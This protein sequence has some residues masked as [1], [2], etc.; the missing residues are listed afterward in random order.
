MRSLLPRLLLVVIAAVVPALC[1]QA[2][3]EN[4]ARHVRQQLMSEEALRLVRFVSSEQQRIVDT[5]GAVLTVIGSAPEVQENVQDACLRL[6]ANVVA[7]SPSYDHIGVFDLQGRPT[8]AATVPGERSDFSDRYWFQRA[9]ETNGVVVGDYIV[10][11]H[12]GK[13]TVHLAKAFRN[14]DGVI[15]GVAAVSLNLEWL[16]EQLT[17][18]P[19]PPGASTVVADRNGTILAR[20]PDSAR[21]AGTPI[22]ARNR[23]LL[24]GNEIRV[25]PVSGLDGRPRLAAFS[26]VNAK[27]YGLMVAVGLDRDAAFATVTDGTRTGIVLIVG[28]L[29]LALTLTALLGTRLIRRPVL[30]LLNAAEHWRSGDLTARTGLRRDQGEFGRLA[31][32]FDGMAAA[33]E[34][35]E[36]ALRNALEST[37][38]TVIVLDRDWRFTYLNN[39]AKATLAHG[40]DFVGQVI[41]NVFP[42]AAAGVF[43]DAYRKAMDEGIPTHASAYY[44]PLNSYWEMHAYPSSDGLT[45][46]ARDVTEERR[47]AAALAESETL[48]RAAF[49]QAAV[50]MT[51]IAI[52]ETVL[53]VNDKLCEITGYTREELL[54]GRFRDIT[55]PDDRVRDR[56]VKDQALAGETHKL[57]LAKRYVR[58]DG[59]IVWVNMIGSALRGDHGRP[60]HFF[61]VIED[62]SERKG[63]EIALQASEDRLRIALEAARMGIWERHLNDTGPRWTPEAAKIYGI[64][65]AGQIE[66]ETWLEAVHPDDRAPT[67]R[68]WDRATAN[69]ENYYE[70]EYRVRQPDGTWRWLAS[71]ARM[72]YD[73]HGNVVR[74]VGAVQ[75]IGERKRVQEALQASET[76]LQ[77]ARAAAGFGVW[78]W[79][80]VADTRIW[81]DD[82][83]CLYGLAPQPGAPSIAVWRA[84]VHPDDL[85]QVL[86]ERATAFESGAALFDNEFRVTW[87]DGS[88]HWLFVKATIVHDAQGKVARIV[89]MTLDVTKSRQTEAELRRLSADLE[90]RV[91]EEMTARE[92]AQVRAAHAERMQA[93]GQLAGG[94]A[95]DFNNVLQAVSGAMTL[96]GRRPGDEAGIRRLAQLASEAT[97]RGASITRRLLAFGRRGDLRAET[98]DPSAL[99]QDL[100]EILAHTLGANIDVRVR[101]EPELRSFLADKGQLETSLINLATNARDAM[102]DGGTLTLAAAVEIVD[103]DA[104]NHPIGLDP[105]PYV[106]LVIHDTGVGMDAATLARASEPFFT[107]KKTGAGTGLGLAM[108]KGFA[109][110]SGGGLRVE[111]TPGRGTTI[112][113]WL[114]ETDPAAVQRAAQ[115]NE[116]AGTSPDGVAIPAARTRVLLV[117]DEAAVREVLGIYLEDAGF[118]VLAAASGSEALALLTAGETV[119]TLITDLSMPG[120]DGLALIQA[121]Q[122]RYPRMPALLLTGYA[123]DG[124]ALAVG[125]AVK[126]SFTLLRKPVQG[127]YLID[128]LRALLAGQS[129]TRRSTEP[130]GVSD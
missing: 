99:L 56:M 15:V 119:D 38:D 9:L 4:E 93:L 92:A 96:I 114:P 121:V 61:G 10:G 59:S 120:M 129:K 97:E 63:V 68:N 102:P 75:D 1:F 45:V 60:S 8:C 95:H 42:E 7:Q 54:K 115:T 105:G 25:I 101:L 98:I 103:A 74:A 16:A 58:K 62:I 27:P 125:G 33:L 128:R 100:R 30:Q 130:H 123:G 39:R 13:P 47:I 83:W 117:D 110:Q 108:A 94:I 88:V 116:A 44:P 80:Y 113:L 77:L 31:T 20:Y 55:H 32:A 34:A 106:R 14:R 122:A 64:G 89:G 53:R 49:E 65:S 29:L 67:M 26:P 82:Q 19:L 18:I 87:P 79:D 104:R 17:Q 84:C 46:F 23:F 6:I 111:S 112:T 24:E 41:W 76:R 43:G 72:L 127:E 52:D 70:A 51:V 66:F 40:R 85:E 36:I 37:T 118:A 90:A 86:A 3:T 69:T 21:Y 107:T 50:G 71:Y 35:R 109:E 91:R 2:Y 126:G 12:V 57:A 22:P 124:A 48:F 78:D 11:Q 5:A 81:S 73:R 28:G